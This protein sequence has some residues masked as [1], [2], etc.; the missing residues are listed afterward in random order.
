MLIFDIL[1]NILVF[2]QKS[3]ESYSLCFIDHISIQAD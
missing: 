2:K 1:R 3:V